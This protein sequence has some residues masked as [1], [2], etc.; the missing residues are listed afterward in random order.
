MAWE[1][2]WSPPRLPNSPGHPLL[3]TPILP[4]CPLSPPSSAAQFL[5]QWS[6]CSTQIHKSILHGVLIE[7]KP[8]KD[9]LLTPTQPPT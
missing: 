6:P 4:S 7:H 3:N 1:A 9:T 8:T 2:S 5:S